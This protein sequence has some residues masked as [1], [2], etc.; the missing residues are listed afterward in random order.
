MFI[1][2]PYLRLALI[3]AGILGGVALWAA[4]G[5]WYGFFFLL[6][7]LILLIGLILLGTVAPAAQSLQAGDFDKAEKLLALTPNPKWLYSAN[8]AYYYLLK[9]SI[10][11]SRRDLEKGEEYLK[12]AEAIELP[13]DNERAMIQLQLGQ[14]AASKDRWNQAQHHLRKAQGYKIT[15]AEIK[16]QLKQ[17]ELVMSQRGQAKA[18]MRMGK[19]AHQ[20]MQMGGKRRRPKLR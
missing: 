7:G 9:G 6:T 15:Q 14:I 5:F 3:G 16:E 10:A 8:R 11:L 17:F 2:N 1:I 13:T 19:D 18:M 4:L 12:I 20:M